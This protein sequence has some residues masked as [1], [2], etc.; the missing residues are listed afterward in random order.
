MKEI[1]SIV[2]E[3]KTIFQ[4][5]YKDYG[6]SWRLFR[7]TSLT[8]QILIKLERIK[9]I[10][11]NKEQKIEDNIKYDY[12]GIIN[13]SLMYLIQSIIYKDFDDIDSVSFEKIEDMYNDF[14]DESIE[15]LN[16]KNHDYSDS[17]KRMRISSITD[18]MLVKLS[19]IK[20]I[21]DK[22]EVISSEGINSNY[23]DIIN[24]CLFSLIKLE[25]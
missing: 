15:L 11:I 6:L 5:K 1:E 7:L 20:Q 19:R 4:N 16:K 3:C 13:Y 24:Y 22:G 23:F 21:E 14:L 18:I 10:E 25:K 2:S 17:W 9:S 8:D 12:I